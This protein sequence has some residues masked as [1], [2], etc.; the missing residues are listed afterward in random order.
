MRIVKWFILVL[1]GIII[2][3]AGFVGVLTI[4]EYR[5][6]AIEEVPIENNQNQRIQL[7]EAM[8]IMT[9]NIGYAGLGEDEDFVMDGG[10]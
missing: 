5:P 9:F 7:N 6:E 3:A 4:M 10:T 8:T 2:V 1:L